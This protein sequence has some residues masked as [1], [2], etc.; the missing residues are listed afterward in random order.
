M[1]VIALYDGTLTGE[2]FDKTEKSRRYIQHLVKSKNYEGFKNYNGIW[3]TVD[4]EAEDVLFTVMEQ[5]TIE[6]NSNTVE[7][8]VVPIKFDEYQKTIRNPFRKPSNRKVLRV[9][10]NGK[11]GLISNYDLLS[12]Q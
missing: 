2:G 6:V 9:N 1:V 4:K 12:Y 8:P 3:Q 5:A 11:N 10:I 7:V